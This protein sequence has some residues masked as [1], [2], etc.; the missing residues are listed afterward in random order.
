MKKIISIF[1]LCV[2]I[3]LSV[4]ANQSVIVSA[5]VWNDNHAPIILSVTP[6]SD[7]RILATNKTQSYT[8]YFRD[9]E[10]DKVSYTITPENWF[11]NPISGDILTT[12][13]DSWSW[14]YINFLYL[15]PATSNISSNPNEKITVTINDWPTVVKKELNLYIY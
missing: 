2:L 9:D 7:P 3:F 15:S 4:K 14:A 13:Y 10:K 12:D 1:I 8:I 5:V 6:N 11:A